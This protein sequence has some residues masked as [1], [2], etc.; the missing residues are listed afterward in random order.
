MMFP[1]LQVM[2]Y[3]PRSPI[4]DLGKI[5]KEPI[6]KLS[7]VLVEAEREFIATCPELNINC[8]GADKGE[9]VRRLKNVLQFYIESAKEFGLEVEN[10]DALILEGE[11]RPAYIKEV[12]IQKSTA[13]N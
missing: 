8:Y 4:S 1:V 9:A 3:N 13:I 6:M 2:K 5:R 12:Y 7:I 10:I 11:I